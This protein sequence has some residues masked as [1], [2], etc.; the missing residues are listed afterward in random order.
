MT[1]IFFLVYCVKWRLIFSVFQPLAL[2]HFFVL[3]FCLKSSQ[4]HACATV[5]LEFPSVLV[6]IALKR[7]GLFWSLK[8]IVV[9]ICILLSDLPSQ[10]QPI[11]SEGKWREC[12]GRGQSAL[13]LL[14]RPGCSWGMPT[15]NGCSA[16]CKAAWGW[17]S[18]FSMH[19]VFMTLCTPG[20]KL[21]TVP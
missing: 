6:W 14:L 21:R 8:K 5:D 20:T 3:C 18:W 15:E 17:N 12:V 19:S 10:V 7:H 11:M 2:S 9:K 1:V 16:S 4:V 13:S